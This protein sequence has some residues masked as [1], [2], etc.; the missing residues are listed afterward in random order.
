MP[1]ELPDRAPPPAARAVKAVRVWL[2]RTITLWANG[3][4]WLAEIIGRS[5]GGGDPTKDE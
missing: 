3:F 4:A 5:I 1:T 2:I